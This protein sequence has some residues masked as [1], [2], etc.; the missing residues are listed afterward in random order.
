MI[1]NNP[2]ETWFSKVYKGLKASNKKITKFNIGEV[3]FR[4]VLS[5]FMVVV[6]VGLGYTGYKINE[7][8]TRAIQIYLG[9][10]TLGKIKTEEEAIAV[11][12]GVKAD[13]SS[14]YNIDVVLDKELRFEPTHSKA[15]DLISKEDLQSS[16][17]S[18]INFLVSGYSLKINGEEVGFLKS[19]EEI[20][21]LLD[22]MKEPFL[23]LEDENS[24]IKEVKILEDIEITKVDIPLNKITKTEDIIEYLKTGSEEIRTHI[25]EVG[26][27]FWTIA[28]IYNTTVEELTEANL[29]RDPK[30][31][32]PGDEVRL[33]MPKSKITVATIE[34]VEY[35]ENLAY[36]VNVELDNSMF[37]NQKK[38]KVEGKRGLAQV[39]ANEIKHNG[40]IVE[41]EVISEEILE[42]PIDELVVK[43]TK[44][45]PKTAA[46]GILLMPTRG[47]VSSPYGMR[48]GRMHKGLDIASSYGT[49]IKA[50]DGGKVVFAGY[51][52]SYGYMIEIDH[53][54][55][56]KTRYAHC[57]KLLV[58]AGTKVYKG[59]HIANMGS[60]GRSTGS[61]L[62]LEVLIN[63]VNKNPSNYVK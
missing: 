17:R 11:M 6:I 31:L 41:K 39:V 55:G 7:I 46:T 18:K 54:N 2:S 58:S 14:T 37:T 38:V 56:Y 20:D 28:K 32:K 52:G 63:G 10:E 34:E 50:A 5:I 59:Q 1:E 8:K 49:T 36:E 33:V 45:V 44:E 23:H 43:G 25:I 57:S 29:D 40:I 9:E 35:T 3:N 16:I 22:T 26:E 51:K 21:S 4:R 30:K 13:L 24:N 53:G 42:K 27:S 48:S 61:H 15:E 47:R 19:E 62:H 60:T 12:A